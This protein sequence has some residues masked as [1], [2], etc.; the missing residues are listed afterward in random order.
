MLKGW[1]GDT[2][3]RPY[4]EARIAFPRLRA[5]GLVSF[6]LD[7]GADRSLLMPRDCI[8]TGVNLKGPNRLQELVDS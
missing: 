5:L 8:L 4:I 6:V 2:T 3:G 7:T 1:F